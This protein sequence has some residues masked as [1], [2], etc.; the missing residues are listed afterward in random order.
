MEEIPVKSEDKQTPDQDFTNIHLRLLDL[1]DINDY[2][3]WVTDDKVNQFC[4]WGRNTSKEVAMKHIADFII[5]HPWYRAI[6]IDDRPIG[7][8]SVTPTGGPYRNKAAIGYVLGSK[9]WGKGI[10]TRAVKKVAAEIFV[11]WPHLVRLEGFVDVDNIASQKVLEKAGFQKGGVLRKFYIQK[12]RARDVVAFSVLSPIFFEE[13]G[14]NEGMSEKKMKSIYGGYGR[15]STKESGSHNK[16]K[17]FKSIEG[18]NR[19]RAKGL[20]WL[21]LL[22]SC[23][24]LGVLRSRY[25]LR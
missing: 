4:S 1:S 21:V 9:Y 20:F 23:L 22:G 15:K 25:T 10:A 11:E 3:V 13:A 6:C 18:E 12:G 24:A 19:K 16:K 14:Y 7:E 5:P 17:F 8:I 2:M